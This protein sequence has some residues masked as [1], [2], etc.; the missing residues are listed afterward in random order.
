MRY[1]EFNL[2]LKPLHMKRILLATGLFVSSLSHSQ[3]L[4]DYIFP[5]GILEARFN[6]TNT[7]G[8]RDKN[9]EMVYEYLIGAEGATVFV[10]NFFQTNVVSRTKEEYY[11]TD[12][13]IYLVNINTKNILS[14]DQE[15]F[16]GYNNCFLKLP[17]KGK[18]IWWHYKVSDE[19][20]YKCSA[21]MI[22]ITISNIQYDAIKVDKTPIQDGKH[23]DN[24]K[25]SVYYVQG[26]GLYKEILP[27]TKRAIYTL[28]SSEFEALKDNAKLLSNSNQETKGLI[29][30][31]E[32]GL[33]IYR[34]VSSFDSASKR[35][36]AIKEP[37]FF[38]WAAKNIYLVKNSKIEKTWEIVKVMTT[39]ADID[40]KAKTN[41]G[42]IY[43]YPKY[44]FI[45]IT[46]L[47]GEKI[48]YT[49]EYINS[50]EL[51][52]DSKYLKQ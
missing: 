28:S 10:S 33:S 47:Q 26:K 20:S 9:F 17:Q 3:N 31:N 32:E 6:H 2:S 35:T 37:T 27:S 24:Y 7:D 29:D 4:K 48:E 44:N 45:N 41:E 14:Y 23:L 39:E 51:D 1:F 40:Y 15:N 46:N 30:L 25:T 19:A 21:T 11:I 49:W 18:T 12:T 13:A 8:S 34:A 16:M 52:I 36:T 43:I 5:D 50:S 42:I 22:K 38:I